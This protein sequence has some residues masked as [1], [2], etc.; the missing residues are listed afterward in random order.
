MKITITQAHITA[1]L[2]ECRIKKHL[3]AH[4]LKAYSIDMKQFLIY[5]ETISYQIDKSSL[6][7][8]IEGLHEK[9]P[10]P[11]TVKRKIAT[12]VAFF[13][14]LVFN[15]IIDNNPMNKINT[16]FK[17]PKLLPRIV[18]TTDLKRLFKQLYIDLE[19]SKTN[20]QLKQAARNTALLELLFSTGIRVSELC[21]LRINNVNLKEGYVR[22]YGK[23]AKE[24][25]LQI[26]NQQVMDS[27][28]L[29]RKLF[30]EELNTSLY[31]FINKLGNR[32]SEQSVRL[33]INR[34]E[35]QLKINQHLTPHMFRH[36]FATMLLEEDVDIRYIQQILGHSSITTTQIYTHVSSCKQKEILIN[37]NPRNTL[38][39]E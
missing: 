7:N 18:D 8:Y 39:D 15:D 17:E 5:L 2:K 6:E 10:K 12:L 24:R 22:I 1:Y 23:G 34:Y 3:N 38:Q 32:L 25:I 19:E 29:Y 16:K 20:Y 37:K 27:L 4:T 30:A 26:G 36:T 11:K 31:F 14:Y 35:H 9:Y 13:N 21:N 33:V 28:N